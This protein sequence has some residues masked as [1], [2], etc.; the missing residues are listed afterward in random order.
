[1]KYLS[2]A[3]IVLVLILGIYSCGGKQEPIIPE[4]KSIDPSP[5]K[6]V[7]DFMKALKD[8][9]FS[10]AYDYVYVPYKDKEGYVIE[11]KNMV[12]DNQVSILSFRL[13]G[14]QIYDRT[15]IVI[16]ELNTKLKSPK[17]G[18]LIE[19]NQKSQYDLGLFD[20]AW[21]ITSG[22]C[23]ENCLETE[24]QYESEQPKPK[25]IENQ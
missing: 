20:D 2:K 18:Q 4:R 25:V 17:T 19:M 14:T 5:T 6:V 11:M 15:A 21:K 8:E 12:K 13:L 3:S 9:N 16:V 24:S 7:E 23:I 10:K 22:N 1:M